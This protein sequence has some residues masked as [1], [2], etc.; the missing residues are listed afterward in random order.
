MFSIITI[1]TTTIATITITI[2]IAITITIITI[3]QCLKSSEWMRS[4]R[5]DVQR[6]KEEGMRAEPW[7]KCKGWEEAQESE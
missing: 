3:V 5:E 7:R 4:L 1:T 2:T 6:W